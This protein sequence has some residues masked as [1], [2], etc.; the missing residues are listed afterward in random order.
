MFTIILTVV[1]IIAI[2]LEIAI[3]SIIHDVSTDKTL[4]CPLSLD[5]KAKRNAT[6]SISVARDKYYKYCNITTLDNSNHSVFPLSSPGVDALYYGT[7]KVGTP[8]QPIN[9]IIDS[10]SSDFWFASTSCKNCQTSN[11]LFNPL[12]STTFVSTND[13]WSIEY[14]DR[15]FAQGFVAYD[16]VMISN[17]SI[18]GQSVEIAINTTALMENTTINGIMGLAFDSL[19]HTKGVETPIKSMISQGLI[20]YPVFGLFLGKE[21]NGTNDSIGNNGEIIFG[22]YNPD[23]INGTLIEVPVDNSLGLWE[24][25]IRATTAGIE[26]FIR[27]I[28]HF[29]G[30]LD[31][32]TTL[33]LFPSRMA[34]KVA[35]AYN[36]I[37][38]KDG[39][40]TISCNSSELSPLTFT[41]G[42]SD[43]S[44]PPA[45]LI[46]TKDGS[47][48]IA[49]F[50]SIDAPFGILGDVFLK[51]HYIIFDHEKPSVY[52]APSK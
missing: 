24:I 1:K 35:E 17:I 19:T 47:S 42:D 50:G 18:I 25:D 29:Q 34:T 22:G 39:T 41:I 32:G 6:H 37:D 49:G 45:D 16:T 44:I 10:G 7:I 21:S 43:F 8:A 36:A 27:N 4:T 30:V 33:M 46:Y 31:T 52:I 26:P 15:S 20:N 9:V 2:L 12:I 13:S 23:H 11:I 38:K 28:G 14:A 51:S 5:P 3:I 48:C 40:Y